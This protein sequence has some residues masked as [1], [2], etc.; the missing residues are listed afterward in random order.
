M[1]LLHYTC[2]IATYRR[3]SQR[4]KKRDGSGGGGGGG[5]EKEREIPDRLE[6]ILIAREGEDRA[7]DPLIVTAEAPYR[8]SG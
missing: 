7:D 8:N 6:N 3:V 2:K 4:E 5:R 1:E